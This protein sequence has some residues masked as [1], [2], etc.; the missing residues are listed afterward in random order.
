M[1]VGRGDVGKDLRHRNVHIVQHGPELVIF[2]RLRQDIDQTQHDQQ[3][4]I[5]EVYATASDLMTQLSAWMDKY[6]SLG[7]SIQ[8]AAKDYQDT[9]QHLTSGKQSVIQK[10]N[11]LE[12]MH[13]APKKAKAIKAGSRI[14]RGRASII[15]QSLSGGLS[16]PEDK[17]E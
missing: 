13:L 1:I 7:E 4:N 3:Q 14:V 11:K 9:T 8:K 16:A 2:R 12:Q 10:I 17:E 6:V 15:P 5:E